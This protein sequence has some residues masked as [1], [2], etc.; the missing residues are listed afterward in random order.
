MA[1]SALI[2]KTKLNL[3]EEYSKIFPPDDNAPN[4]LLNHPH[5]FPPAILDCI[6]QHCFKFAAIKCKLINSKNNIDELKTHLTDKTVP[7]FIER[8]FKNIFNEA[9]EATIKS[10]VIALELKNQISSRT[11]ILKDT[12]KKFD[13]QLI[14][15]NLRLKPAMITLG[16]TFVDTTL[17]K[18]IDFSIK[19]IAS[20]MILKQTK[21]K[22]IK[23]E[24]KKKFEEA[25]ANMATSIDI[26]RRD[27]NVWN[28]KITSLQKEIKKLQLNSK[29]S[30]STS[31]NGQGK[32]L[33]R[34]P[35]QTKRKGTGNMNATNTKRRNTSKRI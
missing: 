11:I 7:D 4:D 35:P 2:P 9:N 16:R 33:G 1:S 26:T 22:E 13:E 18:Y 25:K 31:K 8:K 10:Q 34:P 5:L 23:A 28:K 15:L 19:T 29:A 32:R 14:E 6:N 17:E 3:V 30:S 20:T 24:K 27:I 12:Q 21:D